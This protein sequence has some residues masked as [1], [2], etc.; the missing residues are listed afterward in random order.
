MDSAMR[1]ELNADME[2][3]GGATEFVFLAVEQLL[4][5]NTDYRLALRY[6]GSRKKMYRYVSLMDFLFCEI[7]QKYQ[8]LCFKFYAD[9]GPPFKAIITR[10]NEEEYTEVLL[11]VLD[12]A[13]VAYKRGE[14]PIS[15]KKV[16]NRLLKEY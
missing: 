3:C 14:K 7:Y 8:L 2:I 13:L 1:A 5:M 10:S 6:A 9:K 4:K 16:Y 11:R 15:W 12:I